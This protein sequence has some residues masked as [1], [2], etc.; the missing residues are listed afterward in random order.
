M[1]DDPDIEADP[2]ARVR[3]ASLILRLRELGISDRKVLGAI[4]TVPR[5]AF[6]PDLYRDDAYL[7]RAL[8]I[9]CGQTISAPSVVAMMT[10][11]LELEP[12]HHVLEIG[13]GSGYQA[14]ILARLSRRVTTLERYRTLLELAQ[15][16]WDLL[17]ITNIA[18]IVADGSKGWQTQAPFDRI[19]VTAAAAVAPAKLVA[20]LVDGGILVAP[21]GPVDAVQRLTLFRKEG[22]RVD[23]RDLG[24]VRFVPLIEGIARNL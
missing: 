1:S 9:E 11:A 6:V 12:R 13:T 21:V 15:T 22:T 16:R 20:Q 2:E 14:A 7:D 5:E 24:A 4:E 18:G 23:T 10:T 19:L 17:G 8:P 3:L